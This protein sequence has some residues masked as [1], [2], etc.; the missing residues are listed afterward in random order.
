MTKKKIDKKNV[1]NILGLTSIQEGMLFHHLM[2]DDSERYF[3]QLILKIDG[4]IKNDDFIKSWKNT[5]KSH[6]MLRTLFRWEEVDNAVQ[7]VLKNCDPIIDIENYEEKYC[8]EDMNHHICNEDRKKTFDLQEIPFRIKLCKFQKEAL[9]LVSFHHILLDGWSLG[10]VLNDWMTNYKNISSGYEETLDISPSYQSFVE[11]EQKY[12]KNI[13]KDE[14]Y[15]K[16]YLKGWEKSK[17]LPN[18]SKTKKQ[19]SLFKHT[20]YKLENEKYNKIQK[21][22]TNNS[23][24]LA[25]LIYTVW[26]GVLSKYGNERDVV[27]GTTVS[28]RNLDIHGIEKMVGL[29]I[30][31]LPLRI[32]FGQGNSISSI[33]KTVNNHIIE[34]NSYEHTPLSNIKKS[35]GITA[36]ENLFES[37]VVIE[38]YPLDIMERNEDLPVN[39]KDYSITEQTE[40]DLTLSVGIEKESLS[41]TFVYDTT[42]ISEEQI[43]QMN[44]HFNNLS[45]YI[46]ENPEAN[47]ENFSILTDDQKN[48]QLEAISKYNP[49]VIESPI[50][51]IDLFEKR[52]LE[53]PEAIAIEKNGI[54]I[55]YRE[56]NEKSNMVARYINEMKSSSSTRIGISMVNSPEMIIACLGI[57]KSGCSYVPIDPAYPKKRIQYLIDDSGVDMIFVNSNKNQSFDF[58]GKIVDINNPYIYE[59]GNGT[60]INLATSKTTAY[61]IYTSGTTGNP[62]GVLVNHEAL[63]NYIDW[64]AKNYVKNERR[65][66][67][68]YTSLSFDLTITSIFSPLVTGNTIIIYS[69]DYPQLLLEDIVRDNRVEVIKMTPSH[70]KILQYLDLVNSKIKCLI[71]G[72]EQ[73]DAALAKKLKQSFKNNVE[74]I[75]E[76]GPTE[77]TV[78]CMNYKLNINDEY[79]NVPIGKPIQ[80]TDVFVLDKDMNLL[81]KGSVGEIYIGGKCLSEG[82]LNNEELNRSKFIKNPIKS[83]GVVYKTGDLARIRKDGN[84]EF[85]GRNDSQIKVRGYRVEKEEIEYWISKLESINEVH[86]EQNQ[87]IPNDDQIIAFYTGHEEIN[88]FHIKEHLIKHLPEYMIPTRF[89]KIDSFPLT[90]N[91]KIDSSQLFKISSKKLKAY[92]NTEETLSNNEIIIKE[93]WENIL[94]IDSINI[95]DKFFEIGGNSLNLMKLNKQISQTFNKKIPMVDMFNYNTIRDLAKYVSEEV[96][97][98][99]KIMNV[100]RTESNLLDNDEFAIIGMSAKFPGAKNIEEFLENLKIGKESISFFNSKELLESGIKREVFEKSNYVRAKGVIDNPFL[101][102]SSFFGYTPSESEIMDPQIRLL[103]EFSYNALE[104]AGYAHKNY[105]GKVGIFTGATS[106]IQWLEQFLSKLDGSLSEMFEVGSLNDMYT[107]STRI[108]HKLGLKGPAVTLQTAC[109]TSLVALHLA[110][111]SIKNGDSDIALAGGVSIMHPVKSGYIYQENMI[112]S[113]DGHCRAFDKNAT[114]TVGGDGVGMIAIKSLSRALKD[115]DN[116]HAVIKGSSINNDGE[117]KIGF[118]A[119]SGSGQTRVIKDAIKNAGISSETIDYIEAHGSGTSLGDPIEVD[120]LNKAFETNKKNYCGIGSV[121]TNIGHLDAAAGV[122]GLI[123]TVLQLKCKKIFPSLNFTE[124]NKNISFNDTPF[125]VNTKL[126]KWNKPKNHLRRAGVSS[127]GMGGTNAHV[128][129]EEAPNRLENSKSRESEMLLL[130]AKTK[131]ALDKKKR[132]LIQEIENKPS[133]KLSDIAYTLQVSR[134]KFDIRQ[135]FVAENKKDAIRV[136]SKEKGKG[137]GKYIHSNIRKNKIIFM[138]TGQGK[139]YLNMGID[140]YKKEP[141]FKKFMNEAFNSYED[142]MGENLG[143]IIYPEIFGE[144]MKDSEKKLSM[145]KYAQ[146]AIFAIEYALSKLLIQWGIKPD[147][148]IGY[149][150]GEIA[151]AA[152]SGVFNLKDAMKIVAYRS[153]YMQNSPTGK[154][155]SVPLPEEEISKLKPENISIAVVN[156]SSCIISGLENDIKMF[157]EQMKKRGI[158][159]MILKGNIAAHSHILN[160]ASKQLEKNIENINPK[161]HTIPII[162]NIT[163]DWIENCENQKISYWKNHM[164]KTVY[165]SK[166][167]QKLTHD[168]NTQFIEIGPG[169]DLSVMI[170]R[171]LNKKNQNVSNMIRN[172]TQ[173]ISDT[174]F[175]MNKLGGM[176]SRGVDIDWNEFHRNSKPQKVSLPHY[177]YDY[178]LYE[179]KNYNPRPFDIEENQESWFYS[180]RWEIDMLPTKRLNDSEKNT[181]LI[182]M[183]SKRKGNKLVEKLKEHN[184]NCIIVH[185][186]LKFEQ[187]NDNEY[188]INSN[189]IN[190]YEKLFSKLSNLNISISCVCHLWGLEEQSK[191]QVQKSWLDQTKIDSYFSLIYIGKFIKKY[192]FDKNINIDVISSLTY[193]VKAEHTLY[194]EKSINLGPSMV[195]SQESPN[196]NYSIID[197]DMPRNVKYL[198]NRII[199][200]LIDEIKSDN[201]K[202]LTVFRQGKKYFREYKKS[203]ITNINNENSKIERN[204]VYLLIGG[205][206]H[207]GLNLA[208]VISQQDNVHLILTNKSGFPIREE[209]NKWIIKHDDN[210]IVSKKINELL[211]IERNGTKITILQMDV[212]SKND[213]DILINNIEKNIGRINGVIY[214]AGVTGD[215]SFKIFEETDE[216]FSNKHFQT[217]IDGLLNID[218]AIKNKELDFCYI[219]SSLSP[220]LGGLGFTAYSAANNFI[221]TYVNTRNLKNSVQWTVINFDGWELNEES[222]IEYPVTEELTNSLIKEREGQQIF[223]TTLKLN[224]VEQIVISKT[225]L[226]QRIN[227]YVNRL[228]DQKN[229]EAD[230]EIILYSRPELTSDFEMPQTDVEKKLCTCMK[231][232]FKISEIGIDDNFFELGG[233]SLKAITFIGVIYKNFNVKITLPEF[234]KLPTIRELAIFIKESESKEYKTI[235]KAKKKDLYQ[236]SSAQKR[237]YLMQYMYKDSINYN[238]IKMGHIKGSLNIT[239]LEKTFKKLIQ[240]H[241]SLRTSFIVKEGQPYQK[242]NKDVVF[243]IQKFDLTNIIT[244]K[245]IDDKKNEVINQFIKPFKL[246]EPPLIRVGVIKLGENEHIL[247]LDAHHIISDGISQDI[248]IN[249]FIRMYNDEELSPLSKQYKDFSEWQNKMLESKDMEESQNYWMEKLSDIPKINLP[250]DYRRNQ[251]Q[252]KNQNKNGSQYKF[253]IEKEL[254]EPFK[255]TLTQQNT[256]LFMGLLS[257]Y[258]LFI[259]KISDNKD[260]TVGVPIAGRNHEE[261][262][263]IIGIFVNMLPI[264]LQINEEMTFNELLR[265]TKNSVLNDFE[266]QDYQYE[267]MV[268]DL[269]PSRVQNRNALFD[270]VFALQNMNKPEVSMGDLI[271]S[272]YQY[273]TSVSRFDLLWMVYEQE[274]KLFSIIEYDTDLFFE[275]T[276]KVFSNILIEILRIINQNPSIKVKDIKIK[277]E[278]F[279][280]QSS[281]INEIDEFKI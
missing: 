261:T 102:D 93:I 236:L 124:E 222:S 137:V 64:A 226:H 136:L 68:L 175:L 225:D 158:M 139:Q 253:S 111:Q 238:E 72:G 112:K 197:I 123:K 231:E 245:T 268:K 151:A 135:A 263:N 159:C 147:A 205:L 54:C 141:L 23:I 96:I 55:T 15:W 163:G 167:I 56:L 103:H 233:D 116:I 34:R 266:H 45:K 126:K 20:N 273:E 254:I 133:L 90:F 36:E 140:L 57:L 277:S 281:L 182:F 256:T 14:E 134:E 10:I 29:F 228:F 4:E 186:D 118:N 108:A 264:R 146:P 85:L 150:F 269:N 221:D 193:S 117:Q 155:M 109:S 73:L 177:P 180:P 179:N 234:F 265:Y 143:K 219:L 25:T 95:D 13:D 87:M 145:T 3:E 24:T 176:W 28:G 74:I 19:K 59:K 99:E 171:N 114:G 274:N 244:S 199:T 128:I 129:L 131:E 37:I 165:F 49:S 48:E 191:D 271:F 220:I 223:E 46:L 115:K 173:E 26:G 79:I 105:S 267:Q 11:W 88:D 215:N 47:L 39:I 122:A 16:N 241:E 51:I 71:I 101:F 213:T 278:F 161:E 138:F 184:D 83:E 169:Q 35:C 196:L 255:N 121:K 204:G 132:D 86:V 227:R 76:Y 172:E 250:I 153:Y 164:I 42:K 144:K 259:N 6:R 69:N 31:T 38:N 107:I 211:E 41:F 110:C 174:A 189:N 212:S 208:K 257:V 12:L 198:N 67:A 188:T 70:L 44:I 7:V 279:Q 30:N 229:I 202:L 187:V 120:A 104:D 207:I 33:L 32:D 81:P 262:Q 235:E 61:C 272:D 58:A 214:A 160:D 63:F 9:V 89:I 127:F 246:D 230:D 18:S 249:D 156:D 201:K 5:V 78:G 2:N 200:K 154:M 50:T 247:M 27:F 206:G 77:A 66:F 170:K 52:V 94:G 119:P 166:G 100:D 181:Y 168:N 157:E 251:N 260:I 152:I 275:D 242:I 148:V 98:K 149:S 270:V 60:Y 92:S 239:K 190:D 209:W 217:K 185:K 203:I 224:E 62:K 80:N 240:R 216:E 17:L 183:D 195:I 1:E 97:V 40:F 21:F 130:S 142:I 210:N 53:N 91:G 75:N 237:L 280:T 43:E 84:V 192:Y 162:S 258:N 232:F 106:N 243:K 113:K 65:N 178:T 194:P 276:I 125:F 252:S 248:L 22:I 8:S 82:Y 218:T